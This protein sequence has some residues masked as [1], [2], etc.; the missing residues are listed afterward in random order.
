MHWGLVG[1]SSAAGQPGPLCSLAPLTRR[2]TC[3]GGRSCGTDGH[4][5]QRALGRSVT[6]TRHLGL[7]KDATAPLGWPGG[8]GRKCKQVPSSG[9]S[10][11]GP[12]PRAIDQD[13]G[14]GQTLEWG[15]GKTFNG[16]GREPGAQSAQG[17]TC[18][19][20]AAK[21]APG[22]EATWA[23]TGPSASPAPEAAKAGGLQSAGL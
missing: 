22:P 4:E 14:F 5:S 23:A 8:E 6:R 19:D 21:S 20:F 10:R 7:R 17:P 12:H 11:A 13:S 15:A 2:G 18:H 16:T 9:N 1:L 3:K